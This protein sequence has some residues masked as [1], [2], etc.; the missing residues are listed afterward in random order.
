MLVNKIHS[1]V[2]QYCIGTVMM[3]SP[4]KAI[5]F[6][7][8]PTQALNNLIGLLEQHKTEVDVDVSIYLLAITFHNLSQSDGAHSNF[9]EVTNIVP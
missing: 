8:E 1:K 3:R 2:L 5:F 9:T 4:T 7:Q 6:L